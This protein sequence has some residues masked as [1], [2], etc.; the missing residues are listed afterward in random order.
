M[1]H[2]LHLMPIAEGVETMAQLEALRGLHCDNMQGF[3]FS[4]AVTAAAA[5]RLL[6]SQGTPRGLSLVVDPRKPAERL[7][8]E[9]VAAPAVLER[10]AP[11]PAETLPVGPFAEALLGKHL[12]DGLGTNGFAPGADNGGRVPA[13][14][15]T[16][17]APPSPLP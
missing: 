14:A 17:T 2:S 5:A 10:P 12:R 11:V 6:A 1:A 8:L 15:D 9:R 7:S 3:L 16:P 4:G 13:K